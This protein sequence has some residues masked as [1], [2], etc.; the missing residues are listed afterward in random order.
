MSV[1]W[2]LVSVTV[3][4]GASR[5]QPHGACVLS[6][7]VGLRSHMFPIC[8]DTKTM[9]NNLSLCSLSR[10][11]QE[12]PSKA[13][14]EQEMVWMKEHLSTLGS[15]VVLCHNDLLCKNIIHNNKEGSYLL[16]SSTTAWLIS[17]PHCCHPMADYIGSSMLYKKLENSKNAHHNC[18]EQTKT[19]D[20]NLTMT[21]DKANGQYSHLA[22][23]VTIIKNVQLLQFT[24]WQYYC[25]LIYFWSTKQFQLYSRPHL[26]L[27]LTYVLYLNILSG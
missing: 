19:E 5:Q 11:Q 8:D 26:H 17:L 13:V 3:L 2:E 22:S 12:V 9:K 27:A 14:L 4:P 20:I 10:I 18:P 6:V 1:H 23:L 21:E 16:S 7:H 24:R 25:S 15:P